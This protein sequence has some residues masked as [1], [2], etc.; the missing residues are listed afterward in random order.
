MTGNEKNISNT[1]KKTSFC[2]YFCVFHVLLSSQHQNIR[3][4]NPKKGKLRAISRVTSFRGFQTFNG[5]KNLGI[6]KNPPFYSC[7]N[8]GQS[9]WKSSL[10]KPAHLPCPAQVFNW[11]LLEGTHICF[12]SW[13]PTVF[14]VWKYSKI[15][16]RVL[17]PYL[18]ATFR[19]GISL[20]CNNIETRTKRFYGFLK[21]NLNR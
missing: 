18:F 4:Q 11:L 7:I 17:M 13:K 1:L 6:P 14:H 5:L 20:L 3:I 2:M 10:H 12:N 16:M 21:R 19:N 8:P 15:N 9:R